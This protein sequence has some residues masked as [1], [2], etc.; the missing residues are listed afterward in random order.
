METPRRLV[1][2]RARADPKK[3]IQ[4]DRDS[5]LI[6]RVLS[7]VLSPI[8]A[9]NMVKKVEA[10]IDR[11]WVG[12]FLLTVSRGLIDGMVWGE[13]CDSIGEGWRLVM[14]KVKNGFHTFFIITQ[15]IEKA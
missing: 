2:M 11:K 12:G 15:K 14:E 8:S 7:W 1:A 10:K 5:A 13:T 9:K 6:K 3:T 4:G